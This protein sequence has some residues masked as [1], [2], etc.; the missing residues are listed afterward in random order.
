MAVRE[1]KCADGEMGGLR[2]E[3]R[4]RLIGGCGEFCWRRGHGEFVAVRR[5][6]ILQEEVCAGERMA[7]ETFAGLAAQGRVRRWSS[8]GRHMARLAGLLLLV[9]AVQPLEIRHLFGE[10]A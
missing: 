3:I 2:L 4:A 7:A 10:P 6:Q 8:D 5:E 1:D 9:V